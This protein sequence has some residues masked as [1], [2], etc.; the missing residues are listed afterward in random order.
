MAHVRANPL[1]DDGVLAI[2]AFTL[3]GRHIDPLTGREPD[4][5]LSDAKGMGLPQVYGDYENRIRMED[6]K[7]YRQGLRDY[8]LRY[9]EHTGRPEDELVSFTMST[10]SMTGAPSRGAGHRIT[11]KRSPCSRTRHGFTPP[12]G[13][14]VLPLEPKLD[15]PT[16]RSPATEPTRT[17][18]RTPRSEGPATIWASESRSGC[19]PGDDPRPGTAA[20]GAR[21]RVGSRLVLHV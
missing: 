7:T 1:R 10:G 12:P 14:P 21:L 5:F 19:S 16:S 3:D 17:T 9:H 4:L 6:Y 15:R 11:T 2:D 20:S 13:F 8:L 18:R